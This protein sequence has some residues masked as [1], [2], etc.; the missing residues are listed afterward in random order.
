MDKILI[1]GAGP[2]ARDLLPYKAQLKDFFDGIIILNGVFLLFDDIAT[3]HLITE[4]RLTELDILNEGDYRL[5]LPRLVNFKSLNMKLYN[6]KYELVPV[7][8]AP[9]PPNFNYREYILTNNQNGL[10]IGPV[11]SQKTALGGVALNAIHQA[12]I[13]GASRIY[14]SG[15]DLCFT[16]EWDHA[17]LDRFYRDG[18]SVHPQAAQAVSTNWKGKQIESTGYMVESVPVIDEAIRTIF[19]D[20]VVYDFSEIGLLESTVKLVLKDWVEKVSQRGDI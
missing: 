7:T 6:K 19:K 4:K 11:G 10:L 8:R 18:K 1:I 3:H 5:D 16:K 15:I 13:L 20:I 14:L 12:C 2:S 17:M 9:I